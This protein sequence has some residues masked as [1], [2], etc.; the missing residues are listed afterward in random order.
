V[1]LDSIRPESLLAV[2][3]LS[4][5]KELLHLNRMRESDWLVLERRQNL[6]MAK[7]PLLSG[8]LTITHCALE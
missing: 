2:V 4:N 1:I 3:L 7:L 5:P 6:L 8:E